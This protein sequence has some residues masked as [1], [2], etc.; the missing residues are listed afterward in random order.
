MFVGFLDQAIAHGSWTVTWVL[1][2]DMG[3]G[4]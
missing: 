1:D 4:L 2:C 3:F